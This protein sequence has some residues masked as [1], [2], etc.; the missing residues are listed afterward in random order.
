MGY[1]IYVGSVP[2]MKYNALT[3]LKAK[4]L[5]PGKHADGQ[6]LWLIKSRKE[7]GK[8]IVRL[9][10]NGRRREMGLGRWPDVGLADARQYAA[11]AR[12][13]LRE[14]LDPIDQRSKLKY[15]PKRLTV[16]EAIEGCYEAKQAELKGDGKAGRWMSP[17]TTH[18]IPKIGE[19]AIEDL[20][21][22]ML[23][24]VLEPIWHE[25]PDSARK[26][27]NR[28]NLTLKHAA[29]MGLDVDLQSTMKARALLGKHRHTA[30]HIPSL[31]YKEAPAFYQ[32]LCERKE[33]S[34][35]A[36]RFLMLTVARTTE[37]RLARYDE[38]DGDVWILPPERTKNG[39]EHRVPLIK[40]TLAILEEAR[41]TEEQVFLFLSPTGKP[42][43][44]AA[45]A[46]F[47]KREGFAARPHGFRATFRTWVEETTD[48]PFE[49]K[50]A[51]LGHT[52]DSSVVSAYQR[53]DRLA[54]RRSLMRRWCNH[55]LS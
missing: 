48:S 11:T 46:A 30:Q 50:E 53:S 4:S 52:V 23:K 18:V 3:S 37:V 44:D 42:L 13:H 28:I 36:L 34:C 20:D 21:Q 32:M 5:P 14:G 24:A 17:L 6:G 1:T 40:E 35:L 43:S 47:M 9:V 29:A 16:K 15:Q 25:K 38:I 12:K 19:Q 2:Q 41:Q 55:L 31:P 33:I 22:H 26:A 51:V 7:A 27:V 8:W 10:V 45:M 49:L 54:R 39:K